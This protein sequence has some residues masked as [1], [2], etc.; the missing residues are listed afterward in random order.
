MSSSKQA[1]MLGLRSCEGLWI[2]IGLVE[3]TVDSGLELANGSE[4]DAW[5]AGRTKKHARSFFAR[6]VM[7]HQEAVDGAFAEHQL[8]LG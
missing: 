5:A 6:D 7:P 3:E 1:W 4:D 2:L 8:L